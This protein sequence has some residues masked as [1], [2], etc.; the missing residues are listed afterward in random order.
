MSDSV[1]PYDAPS[2]LGGTQA[3]GG[4]TRRELLAAMAMQG[5]LSGENDARFSSK[6][7]AVRAVTEMA[8]EFSDALLAEL[9][10]P[11]KP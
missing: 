11:V 4:L 1:F 8:V 10:K 7:E 2:I 9:S 3:V 5:I 6:D